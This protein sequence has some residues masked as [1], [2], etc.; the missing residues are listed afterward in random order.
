MIKLLKKLK[1]ERGEDGLSLV[2]MVIAILLLGILAMAAYPLLYNSILAVSLNNITTSATVT[3]QD[4]TEKIR[5]EPN[6]V[7]ISNILASTNT[8]EDG[9]GQGY[10]VV[11]ELPN[12]CVDAEAVAVN[13][14]A[15]RDSDDRILV[16]QRTQIFVPPLTGSFD[17]N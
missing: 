5:V 4:L 7:N 16:Q 3:V 13:F 9:R 11:I 15:T 6:C 17:L 2:E 8:F 10:T 12:G 1:E 14:V